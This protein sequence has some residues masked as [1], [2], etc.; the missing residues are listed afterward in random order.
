LFSRAN[1][2]LERAKEDA[3]KAPRPALRDARSPS[4]YFDNLPP[5]QLSR[6]VAFISELM[7]QLCAARD[8]CISQG[9]LLV[10]IQ[11]SRNAC[12]SADHRLPGG[13]LPP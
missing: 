4:R 1:L 9:Q 7:A 13:A 12:G 6:D 8:Q 10:L 2:L 11:A 5:D 3:R